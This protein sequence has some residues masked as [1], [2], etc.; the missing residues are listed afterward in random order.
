MKQ[1]NLELVKEAKIRA[2]KA[3]PVPKCANQCSECIAPLE[4]HFVCEH[5][6]CSVFTHCW[7]CEDSTPHPGAT[8][9]YG[10]PIAAINN[11]VAAKAADLAAKAAAK[12]ST[13]VKRA[14][15]Q[16]RIKREHALNVTMATAAMDTVVQG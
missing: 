10:E 8:V 9:E 7:N 3:A 11:G 1:A 4:Q 12:A 6:Q 15:G 16:A 5:W 2:K 14:E 13:K